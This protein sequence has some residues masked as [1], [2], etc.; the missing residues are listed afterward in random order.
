MSGMLRPDK[1]VVRDLR[2]N[3]PASRIIRLFDAFNEKP[4]VARCLRAF[5]DREN[6]TEDRMNVFGI[7]KGSYYLIRTELKFGV[8]EIPKVREFL[9]VA[10]LVGHRNVAFDLSD[11]QHISSSAMGLIANIFKRCRA[12]G[13]KCVIVSPSE[14]VERA[15]A[16]T[17][18]SNAIEIL[19]NVREVE[20]AV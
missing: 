20:A 12:S 8:D 10:F 14:T 15:L 5:M 7:E 4:N 2:Q 9:E 19:N 11:C 17:K 16:S 18:V 6:T 3:C 1:N 13:G